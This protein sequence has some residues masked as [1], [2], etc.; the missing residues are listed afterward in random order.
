[1]SLVV[2][3]LAQHRRGKEHLEQPKGH[4]GSGGT[5][6]N[7]RLVFA[8]FYDSCR[9]SSNAARASVAPTGDRAGRRS[10]DYPGNQHPLRNISIPRMSWLHLGMLVLRRGWRSQSLAIQILLLHNFNL[11]QRTAVF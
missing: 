3:V 11:L 8:V 4:G 10:G 9:E 6:T 5:G 1:M 7:A 2:P